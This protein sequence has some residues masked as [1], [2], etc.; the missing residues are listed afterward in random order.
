MK[1]RIDL[2]IFIFVLI[3]LITHQIKIYGIIMLFAFFHEMGHI[4]AGIVLGFKPEKIEIMPW[5]LSA[6]FEI[7]TKDYNKKIHK[8]NL[9]CIKRMLIAIAGPLV[10]FIIALLYAYNNTF[11]V[12]FFKVEKE[13]I[14]YSNL[15]LA[16]FNLIPIY[17]LDGGRIL[18][19]IIHILKGIQKSYSDI[20]CISKITVFVLTLITSISILYLK[21]IALVFIILYLWY[22]VLKED[23][24]YTKR[25]ELYDKLIIKDLKI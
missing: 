22:L 4:L 14:V 6:S 17:P 7:K 23:K 16:I 9:L 13:I 25:K 11:I 15:L 24:I 21:N 12:D 2:K 5:G 3:F 19:E 8:G 1:I 18:K 10:N 20:I